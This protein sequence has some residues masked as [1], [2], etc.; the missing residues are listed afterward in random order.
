MS[1]PFLPRHCV[2]RNNGVVLGQN[3]HGAV[4]H[5]RVKEVVALFPS[6]ISPDDLELLHIILIDLREWG[7][8]LGPGAA[9]IGWPGRVGC[10][11]RWSGP[12]QQEKEKCAHEA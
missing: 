2:E 10:D 6:E 3:V 1:P 7:I 11:C 4:D 5:G 8:L 9:Q 12:R